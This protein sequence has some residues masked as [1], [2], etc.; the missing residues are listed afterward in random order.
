M[1]PSLE[2]QTDYPHRDDRRCY[3]PVRLIRGTR[4][5]DSCSLV[6]ARTTVAAGRLVVVVSALEI[7]VDPTS[8]YTAPLLRCCG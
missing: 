1:V 2:T 4:T 7:I 5:H 8:C 6:K 3:W